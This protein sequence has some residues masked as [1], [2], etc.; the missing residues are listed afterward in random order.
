MPSADAARLREEMTFARGY[1]TRLLD[2]VPVSDWFRQPTEGITH[3]AWQVGHLALGQYRL[4]LERIRGR[5]PADDDLITEAFL[6]HFGRDLAPTPDPSAYPPAGVIR[7]TFD[8][9]HEQ[10]LRE[11]AAWED[12]DLAAPAVKPHA[13]AKTKLACLVWCVQHE[14]IHAGQIGLLRRLLGRPP[15]W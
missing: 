15:L 13:I 11:W 2:T 6:A 7:A 5:L 9:V 8:R 1:T 12:A 10:V 14:L 3:V 4:G